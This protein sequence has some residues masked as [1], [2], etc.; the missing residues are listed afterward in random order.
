MQWYE[1][2]VANCNLNEELG[3]DGQDGSIGWERY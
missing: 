3:D 1:N 2:E